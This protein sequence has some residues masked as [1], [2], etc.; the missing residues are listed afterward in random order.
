MGNELLVVLIVLTALALSYLWIYPRFAGDSPTKLAWLDAGVGAVVFAVVAVIFWQSDPTFRFVFFDTSWFV[1]ALLTYVALEIPLFALY[2][3]ARNISWRE[4]Y[5]I[6]AAPKGS[7]DAGWASASVKSVEKQLNDTKWDGLRTP[8]ARRILVIAS[9]AILL[10]GT[11]FLFMVGDNEWAI[12]SL[13]HILLIGVC[14]FLLRQS[15]RLVTEAPVE[16]L[17]ERLQRKRDTAYLFAYRFLAMVVVIVAIG[18]MAIAILMDVSNYSDGFTYTISFTWPQVQ[19]V[20][21]L[22]YGYAFMLP[23]MVLAWREA[24]LEAV[25]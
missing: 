2:M 5:G 21:W 7:P 12:Y 6:L 25:R 17:D 16:A 9:N 15:V 3:K 18:A 11:S 8:N 4:Y 22:L 14:W 19:G 24:K 10:L 13:I 23:A 20:F 1:F